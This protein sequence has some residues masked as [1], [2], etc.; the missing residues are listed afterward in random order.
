MVYVAK[1]LFFDIEIS[2]YL[3]EIYACVVGKQFS[4]MRAFLK[5]ISPI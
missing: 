1:N 4:A 2:S 3:S 5:P